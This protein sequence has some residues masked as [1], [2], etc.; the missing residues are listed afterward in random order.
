MEDKITKY[1][2]FGGYEQIVKFLE[3]SKLI[4]FIDCTCKDFEMRRI[5]RIGQF[6][7]I[8]YV[9]E[10]C[11]HL[12]PLV[13]IYED[14]GFK[15]KQPKPMIG[16]DKCSAEL[17][18]F[19]VDRSE[20][21]CEMYMCDREGKEVH[22]KVPKTNGG[23]YNKDNCVLLCKECHQRITYQKWQGTPGAEP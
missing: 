16:T 3:K 23:K 14:E 7:D 10:P 12:L 21:M 5:R 22:R 19:L 2:D 6:S 4:Y 20:G 17:R 11:K 18:K 9:A 13:K 8:K 1:F 15:I